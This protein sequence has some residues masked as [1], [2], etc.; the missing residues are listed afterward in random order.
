MVE[1]QFGWIMW[2]VQAQ[3]LL[4]LLAHITDGD[5]TTVVIT[6]TPVFNVLVSSNGTLTQDT[7]ELIQVIFC[8]FFVFVHEAQPRTQ[9]LIAATLPPRSYRRYPAPCPLCNER[10]EVKILH[11]YEVARGVVNFAVKQKWSG[12]SNVR[13]QMHGLVL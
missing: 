8:F 13:S 7:M 5:V 2:L 11:G 4:Y 10:G 12:L 3:K 1:V 6:R 9:G